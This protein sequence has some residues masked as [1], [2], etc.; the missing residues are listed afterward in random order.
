MRELKEETGFTAKDIFDFRFRGLVTFVSDGEY[1]EYM[2]VFTAR[3]KT[4]YL[5]Q[6]HCDEGDLVW[7]DMKDIRNLP[8]WAGDLRMFDLL[9]ANPEDTFFSLKLEYR[10]DMLTS[11]DVNEY[12]FK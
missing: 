10:G 4:L 7:V 8:V 1:T 2:H 9:F 12:S 3:A 5:P 11:T 6:I